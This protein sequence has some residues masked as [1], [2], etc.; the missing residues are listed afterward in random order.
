MNREKEKME[1]DG[2]E[3]DEMTE[4]DALDY[5]HDY[6]P[7]Q[8]PLYPQ[9]HVLHQKQRQILKMVPIVSLPFSTYNCPFPSQLF[10][11]PGQEK[12]LLLHRHLRS[13]LGGMES[14]HQLLNKEESR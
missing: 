13:L 4:E 10:A 3:S 9:L 12:E 5:L 1:M 11:K 14:L 6:T 2:T 7:N 8:S